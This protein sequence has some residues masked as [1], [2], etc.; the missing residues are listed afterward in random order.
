LPA[1]VPA[2]VVSPQAWEYAIGSGGDFGN[3]HCVDVQRQ[4][5]YESAVAEIRGGV[6]AAC[7]PIVASRQ[8]V[9][10]GEYGAW[11]QDESLS[12]CPRP[13]GGRSSGRG[14]QQR[15]PM[16]IYFVWRLLYASPSR[17]AD[18]GLRT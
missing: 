4:N 13:P 16:K 14:L 7:T 11:D 15:F 6:A 1:G 2:G 17:S 10:G 5:R 9:D 12:P 3:E 8:R 18:R